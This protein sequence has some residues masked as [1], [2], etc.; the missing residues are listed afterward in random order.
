MTPNNERGFTLIEIVTIILVIGVLAAVATIKME[1]SID[2]ALYEQ[3][4]K[5]MDQ[6]AIAIVG[7]PE[8]RSAGARSDFGYVGDVGA[9]PSN[10]DDLV[11]N[12]GGYSTWNG[13][14]MAGGF[15]NAA[16]KEDGWNVPYVYLDS[17]IRSIGSGSNI[18][19]RIVPSSA[20]LFSNQVAGTIRDANNDMPGATYDDSLTIE[21][22]YPDGTG[23]LA[24]ATANPNHFGNF[25]YSG[26][27]IGNHILRVIYEPDTD[28]V[29]IPVT[30]YP[31]KD[32]KLDV[33]FPADLW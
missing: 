8:V 15:Q 29:T 9:F 31:G 16:F 21:L 24:V 19:K 22:V 7:S 4:K 26:I 25:S 33:V 28:T 13:P 5:E 27:P 17:I 11:I 6:L 32:V 3:T 12:P 18:D 1:H 14:Y 2:S 10:L 20:A 23:A 30:V